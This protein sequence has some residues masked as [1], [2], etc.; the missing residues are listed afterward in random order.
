[1]MGRGL[2]TSK[3][4]SDFK[5]S[6]TLLGGVKKV[7]NK[8]NNFVDTPLVGITREEKKSRWIKSLP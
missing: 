8:K 1:M 7:T 4:M 2:K 5:R 6:K 3:S